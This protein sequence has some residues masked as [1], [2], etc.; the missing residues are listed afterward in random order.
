MTQ[1]VVAPRPDNDFTNP[2]NTPVPPALGVDPVGPQLMLFNPALDAAPL[3]HGTLTQITARPRVPSALPDYARAN[4]PAQWPIGPAHH[5]ELQLFYSVAKLQDFYSLLDTRFRVG[6]QD[7]F[8][9]TLRA[10][11]RGKASGEEPDDENRGG[12]AGRFGIKMSD[13]SPQII[14]GFPPLEQYA[15]DGTSEGSIVAHEYHHHI[16]ESLAVDDGWILLPQQGALFPEPS[17][18]GACKPPNEANCRRAEVLEGAADG[19]AALAVNRGV[20]GTLAAPKKSLASML[21]LCADNQA[22]GDMVIPDSVGARVAC[23]NRV[24]GFWHEGPASGA[25]PCARSLNESK[26]KQYGNERR[27]VVSGALFAFQRR[28]LDSGVGSYAPAHYMLEGQRN[29]QQITDNEVMYLQGLVEYLRGAPTAAARRYEYTARAAFA[30]KG[31][32]SPWI[33][34]ASMLGTGGDIDGRPIARCDGCPFPEEVSAQ[35]LT[36]SGPFEWSSDT[37]PPEVDVFAPPGTSYE[38]TGAGNVVHLELSDNAAFSGAQGVVNDTVR[39]F[40]PTSRVNCAP[41]GFFRATPGVAQWQ[42]AASAAAAKNGIVYYRVRQCLAGGAPCI[43]STTAS[44]PAY[45]VLDLP[46]GGCNNQQCHAAP[47]RRAAGWP[48]LVFGLAAACAGR[49]RARRRP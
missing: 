18:D 30:E 20:L 35:T 38:T 2:A 19:F 22:Y 42:A 39:T 4:A 16:Q 28:F 32:F 1:P 40:S 41:P 7:R 45:V 29:L 44:V 33:H 21:G 10:H 3:V 46:P 9:T 8:R 15:Y 48:W 37:D 31:V 34:V 26:K 14:A 11:W 25:P 13:F 43:A 12:R 47:A 27:A 24:F 49:R 5:A 23:T 6:S 17:V 36:V